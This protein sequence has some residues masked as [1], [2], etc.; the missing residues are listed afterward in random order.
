[1]TLLEQTEARLVGFDQLGASLQAETLRAIEADLRRALSADAP[2]AAVHPGA[3][4]TASRNEGN[5]V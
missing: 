5:G 4:L 2:T 1:M 3:Q